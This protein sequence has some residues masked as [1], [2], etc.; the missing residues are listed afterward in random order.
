M[1]AKKVADRCCATILLSLYSIEPA[2]HR[3]TIAFEARRL[4]TT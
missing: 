4:A 2:R 1:G 3:S